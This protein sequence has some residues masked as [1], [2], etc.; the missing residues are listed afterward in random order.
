MISI[1]ELLELNNKLS[2]DNL[3]RSKY[4]FSWFVIGGLPF[5]L[6]VALV[7]YFIYLLVILEGNGIIQNISYMLLG[8]ILMFLSVL[9]FRSKTRLVIQTH[10]KY[11]L[12]KNNGWDA[13][14]ILKIRKKYI[15]K[16]LKGKVKLTKKNILFIIEILQQE[17]KINKYDYPF[18]ITGTSIVIGAFL[19]A[20]LGGLS[21]YANDINDYFH[22]SKKILGL[23][24][25]VICLLIFSE[26][27]LLKYW[28]KDIKKSTYR[29]EQVFQDIYLEK[30]SKKNQK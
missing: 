27:A 30:I 7:G 13:M 23:V 1:E 20:F 16:S 5:L 10:Y 14:S 8:G 2:L 29:L 4:N 21:K 15:K 9:Y 3:I 22:I 28:I 18:L 26:F 17:K 6:G 11:A 19:G 12:N 25:L 24:L